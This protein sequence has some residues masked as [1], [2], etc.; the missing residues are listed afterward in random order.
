M[1]NAAGEVSAEGIIVI[2]TT[3]ALVTS[4]FD[5]GVDNW[6]IISNSNGRP[7]HQPISRGPLLSYYIYGLDA[8]IHRME[9][10][11]DSMRWYF[12]AP[13]KF[14]GN[15]WASYGGTLDF[16]LSSAEGTFDAANLNLG[17]NGNLVILECNT[18][19]QNAGITLAMPLSTTFSYDGTTT[20][21]SLPLNE[22]QGWVKDPKNIILTWTAPTQCEMVSVLSALSSIRILGDFTRGIE[23]V[24]LDTVSL[25]H[26]QGIP[27]ACYP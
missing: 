23:S 7:T 16:V 12:S 21:F 25:K 6:S 5:S 13:P 11:D 24:A 20:Q 19:N 22:R 10:G 26:G 2:T 17:G 18:C 15:Q 27:R 8:V 3:N 4:T 1:S 9:N 14:L